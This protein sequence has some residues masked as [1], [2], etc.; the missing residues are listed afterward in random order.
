[1]FSLNGFGT[2][3]YGKSEVKSDDSYIATEWFV[4]LFLPIF[5][6]A[7]YRVLRGNTSGNVFGAK[8]QYSTTKVPLNVKQVILIYSSVYGLLLIMA[9]IFFLYIYLNGGGFSHLFDDFGCVGA[10]C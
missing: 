3:L 10:F 5:P 4:L 9:I 8:T 6:I 2:A 7:S 1:M